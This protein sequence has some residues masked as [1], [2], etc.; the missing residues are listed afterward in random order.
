MESLQGLHVCWTGFLNRRPY[1]NDKWSRI[2]VEY[3]DR[4]FKYYKIIFIWWNY[5]GLYVNRILFSFYFDISVN[6]LSFGNVKL[7]YFCVF[8]MVT[9]YYKQLVNY[10]LCMA[11]F[12]C[13]HV[14]VA[15]FSGP[16]PHCNCS[17]GNVKAC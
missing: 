14:H 16:W 4:F 6:I 7:L 10:F 13:V 5:F 17:L 2:I 8:W 12:Y 11:I 1:S 9:R 3:R 15:G